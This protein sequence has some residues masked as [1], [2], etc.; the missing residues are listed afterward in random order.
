MT[1]QD[2]KLDFLS[3]SEDQFEEAISRF[4]K[5]LGTDEGDTALT[6]AAER[7]QKRAKETEESFAVRPSDLDIPVTI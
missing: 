7:G 6:Q 2:T 5:W 3:M 4:T 1:D